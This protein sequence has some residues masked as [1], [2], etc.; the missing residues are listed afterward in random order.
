MPFQ[1]CPARR[2]QISDAFPRHVHYKDREAYIAQAEECLDIFFDFD[3]VINNFKKSEPQLRGA[4]DRAR[5]A[6][7]ELLVLSVAPPPGILDALGGRLGNRAEMIKLARELRKTLD[8]WQT[9]FLK[10]KRSLSPQRS[11]QILIHA[12]KYAYAMCPGENAKAQSRVLHATFSAYNHDRGQ[13]AP[14]LPGFT[15]DMLKW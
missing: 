14:A 8:T 9:E 4:I 12:L 15:D 2:K 13:T 6:I 5:E 1:F 7:D 3:R 11:M 10:P